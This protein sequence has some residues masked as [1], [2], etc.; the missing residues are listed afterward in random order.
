MFSTFLAVL[1]LVSAQP[2]VAQKA[3]MQPSDVATI[4]VQGNGQVQVSPDEA[5]VRLGV[6]RQAESAQDAQEQVNVVAQA[7]LEGIARLGVDKSQVQ[8]SQLTLFPIYQ[9]QRPNEPSEPKIVGYRATNVVSVRLEKLNLIG[10][11]VDAGLKAGAN[12]VEGVSFDLKDDLP[13]RE[14]AL[15][16]AVKEA[17]AKARA[18]AEALDV[19]LG[20]VME[21][22][23]GGVNIRPPVMENVRMMAMAASDAST[24]VSPGQVSVSA[25]VTIRFRI[26]SR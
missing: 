9:G 8:S 24:P 20:D 14:R 5:T 21:V 15:R 18:I 23:E 10:P 4:T 11:V 22:Q 13:A 26:P 12:Q 7:L 1:L 19:R 2:A 16:Q 6:T 3:R 25:A 17:R